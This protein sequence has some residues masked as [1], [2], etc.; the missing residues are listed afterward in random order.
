LIA[1]DC[2]NAVKDYVQGRAHVIS[3]ALLDQ[4]QLANHSVPLKEVGEYSA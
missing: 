4:A 1:L 2:V 3:G